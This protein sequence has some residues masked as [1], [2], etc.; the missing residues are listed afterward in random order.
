MRCYNSWD[1][2][3][4]GLR[5]KLRRIVEDCRRQFGVRP[6]TVYVAAGELQDRGEDRLAGVR[7]VERE[8]VARG[9]YR[10]ELDAEAT[11]AS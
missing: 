6:S 2:T 8:D 1:R 4:R 3:E 10:V 9:Q 11:T 5:D 7:V